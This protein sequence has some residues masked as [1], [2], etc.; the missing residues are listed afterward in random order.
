MNTALLSPL[1]FCL[2]AA[3][4]DFAKP[5][6][7]KAGDDYIRVEAPGWAFPCLHDVDK[8]GKADLVVGQFKDG[9]MKVYKR[10]GAMEFAEGQWLKAGGKIAEVPGVW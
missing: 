3:P 1:V 10:T 5:E 7:I 4:A 9:R 2:A 8:D 6:R